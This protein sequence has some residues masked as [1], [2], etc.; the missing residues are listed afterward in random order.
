MH[1]K[2]LQVSI[3]ILTLCLDFPRFAQAGEPLE[4]VRTAIEKAV[5]ILKDPG[6]QAKDKKENGSIA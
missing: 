5:Q 4:L 1:K 6:L 2:I 3:F